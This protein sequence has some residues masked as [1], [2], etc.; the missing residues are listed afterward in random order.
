MEDSMEP[1]IIRFTIPGPPIAKKRPRF[2]RRGKFVGVYSA[3]E[4]EEGLFLLR[5]SALIKEQGGSM[6]GPVSVSARFIFPVPKSKGKRDKARMLSGELPHTKKPDVDNCLKFVLD[7]LN[8]I[9][10]G[11][12]ASV[13]EVRAVKEFGERARTEIEIVQFTGKGN[14]YVE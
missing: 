10:W 5:A 8:G 7:C 4:T 3:Q 2:V 11:D 12:D 14:D 1:R 13:C 9:A 6:D